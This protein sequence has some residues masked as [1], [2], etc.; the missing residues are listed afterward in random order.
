M[1]LGWRSQNKLTME[2][3]KNFNHLV[4]TNHSFPCHHLK[5]FVEIHH[6]F[7]FR[8]ISLASRKAW[9]LLSSASDIL[10]CLKPLS[11]FSELETQKTATLAIFASCFFDQKVSLLIISKQFFLL[12][13]ALPLKANVCSRSVLL[14][15]SLIESHS[16]TTRFVSNI[17]IRRP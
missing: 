6:L 17:Y 11:N 1:S 5:A 7:F 3:V 10:S 4:L 13:L 12:S 2:T 16:I 14:S 15:D 8:R 9:N